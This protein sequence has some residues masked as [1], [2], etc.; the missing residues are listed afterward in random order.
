MNAEV[1]WDGDDFERQVWVVIYPSVAQH[2]DSL[3]DD[4]GGGVIPS[5]GDDRNDFMRGLRHSSNLHIVLGD[6]EGGRIEAKFKTVDGK[7]VVERLDRACPDE[8]N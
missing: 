3:P 1:S 7:K 4:P 6:I 2:Y 5:V 8:T